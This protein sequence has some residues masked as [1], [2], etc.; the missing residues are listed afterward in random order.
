[1]KLCSGV[2]QRTHFED[3]DLRPPAWVPKGAVSA[4][5]GGRG[6]FAVCGQ[7]ANRKRAPQPRLCLNKHPTHWST[8]RNRRGWSLLAKKQ[9]E[10]VVKTAGEEMN[11]TENSRCLRRAVL[12]LKEINAT[13]GAG[14]RF[15]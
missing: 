6:W 9:P 2:V 1:M 13:C 7:S 14:P 8:W 4:A 5:A 12:L 3:D 10:G 15:R 11:E